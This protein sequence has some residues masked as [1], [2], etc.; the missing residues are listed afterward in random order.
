MKKT[1]LATMLMAIACTAGAQTTNY[2][3]IIKSDGTELQFSQKEIRSMTIDTKASPTK[4]VEFTDGT[5]TV[6]FAAMNLGATSVADGT[7]SYGYYYA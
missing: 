4:F 6:Q 3:H 7:S 2:V 1:I 5:N